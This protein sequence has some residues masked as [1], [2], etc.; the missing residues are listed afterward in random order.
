M[1][2]LSHGDLGD[3]GENNAIVCV[4]IYIYIYICLFLDVFPAYLCL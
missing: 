4:Y 1:F 2:G 3:L